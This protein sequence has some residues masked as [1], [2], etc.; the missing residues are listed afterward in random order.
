MIRVQESRL[1]GCGWITIFGFFCN[2]KQ[3]FGA[4]IL[5]LLW[6]EKVLTNQGRK[7]LYMY[8]GGFEYH[9]IKFIHI[10]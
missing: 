3:S 9:I 1:E 7:E 5:L 2:D 10:Y 8:Y 6:S 4:T